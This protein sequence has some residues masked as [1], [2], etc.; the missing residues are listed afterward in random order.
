MKQF[1][2]S[3]RRS[4]IGKLTEPVEIKTTKLVQG[5]I[6]SVSNFLLGIK[7]GLEMNLPITSFDSAKQPVSKL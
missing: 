2:V 3:Q 5:A 1:S 4:G 6:C 7:W